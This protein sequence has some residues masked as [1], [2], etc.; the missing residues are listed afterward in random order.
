MYEISKEQI[1]TAINQLAE[2]PAKY[3][4]NTIAMLQTL[5]EVV[6]APESKKK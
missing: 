1:E 6:V 2:A 5:K 3:T 4:F